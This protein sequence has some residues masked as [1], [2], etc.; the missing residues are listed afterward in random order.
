MKKE[1]IAVMFTFLLAGCGDINNKEISTNII[2]K[3]ELAIISKLE[4]E[5]GKFLANEILVEEINNIFNDIFKSEIFENTSIEYGEITQGAGSD[6]NGGRVFCCKLPVEVKFTGN[7]EAIKRFV[8]YFHEIDRVISF[9]EF[10]I[11]PLENNKY[12]VNTV[13]NFL[14]KETGESLSKGEKK[15]TIQKNEVEVKEETETTLRDFDASMI[16]RPS[17]S[18][19]A[20]ISLGV[21]SDVDYRVY[22]DSNSKQ[23]V[24]ITFSNEGNKCFCEY[25]IGNGESKRTSINPK[26]K[27]LFD[28]LSCDIN[29]E[30]DD[31]KVDLHVIN[32]SNKKVSVA[33]YDDDD[34]RV[35]I[36]EKVGNIE[37]KK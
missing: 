16:I 18:D 4:E 22:S 6:G 9:G 26:G 24:S 23:D 2:F 27:I 17:N 28:V 12:E 1:L 32:N 10:E 21:V 13:I 3:E 11:I 31:I 19:S 37:V 29:K 5:K 25:R 15:Y 36:I 35:N 7:E 20:A 30:D 8:D 34:G 14:G 33:V